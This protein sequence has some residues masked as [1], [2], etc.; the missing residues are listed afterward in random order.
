M[1][2]IY[3]VTQKKIVFQYDMAAMTEGVGVHVAP[4]CLAYAPKASLAH[5]AVG[6][7]EGRVLIIN[8]R[9]GTVE[10]LVDI[11]ALRT[12]AAPSFDCTEIRYSP[13][14]EC[15][16]VGMSDGQLVLLDARVGYKHVRGGARP[17]A[18]P[19]EAMDWSMD[20]A[21][22]QLNYSADG[23]WAYT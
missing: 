23:A 17:F 16:A 4:R 11:N 7:T 15:L 8:L 18:G 22:L 9:T 20:C 5:I 12:D 3:S 19:V 13:N 14:S 21:F 1:A 10:H 6:C 2:M